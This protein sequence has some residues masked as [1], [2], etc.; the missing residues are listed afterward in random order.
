MMARSFVVEADGGSRGNPGPA[1]YGAVVRDAVT[2]EVLIEVAEFLGTTTNNVAEY[3]GAIAGLEQ[4]RALDAAAVVE[5]R[6]DSKLVV[7]QMT[8]RWKIKHPGMRELALA[9]RSVLPPGQVTY[10]WVPRSANAL[11]DALVNEM[12][13]LAQETG[14]PRIHRTAAHPVAAPDAQDVVGEAEQSQARALIEQ[15][16]PNRMIGWSD[17]GAPTLTVMARHGATEYSLQKRFSGSGGRD[18]PLAPIGY[19]Q[20]EALASELLARGGADVIV[21]SPL[22]RTRQTAQ[23]IATAVDADIEVDDDFA[24]CAF[25]AWDGLTFAQVRDRWP[26]HLDEWL[27][28][29]DVAPPGGESFEQ[30]RDRV[31]RGRR[32]VM[33]RHRGCRVIVVSHV[34]PIKV[35]VSLAVDAGLHSLF[36]M[37]LSPCSITTLAWFADGNS[38]MFGFSESAHLR[39]VPT[40]D[41]T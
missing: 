15:R 21:T 25:G 38:S 32:R 6:L 12:L 30:V 16:P 9:A 8:G 17:L 2:G 37:E 19:S 3:R 27:A 33:E 7:E 31:D 13:D 41:G 40:P 29:T 24:E 23:V 1:A 20:A 11:A 22:L 39:H 34:T 10:A 35:M 18:M 36:R 5:V 4:A 26:A 28:A 14:E